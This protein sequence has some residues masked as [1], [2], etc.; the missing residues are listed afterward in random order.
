VIATGGVEEPELAEPARAVR[1]AG[2]R[3]ELLPVKPGQIQVV[4]HDLQPAQT[5]AAGKTLDQADPRDYDALLLPGGAVN[6]GRLRTELDVQSLLKQVNGAGKP[7]AVICHALW[8]LVPGGLA[9][10][11]TLTSYHTI[12][13]GLR[14]AGATGVDR[15]VVVHGTLV[16]SRQPGDIPAV[17]RE[18]LGLF[19][20][21]RGA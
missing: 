17:T 20:T 4:R 19:A 12:Q 11:R 21:A 5:F 18:M 16:T 1:E 3:T 2:A 15:E 8:G 6:A 14:N 10:G 9:R 7:M 13:D